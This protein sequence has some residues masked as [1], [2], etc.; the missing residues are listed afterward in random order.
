MPNDRILEQAL[1]YQNK[2][3]VS[4]DVNGEGSLSLSNTQSWCQVTAGRNTA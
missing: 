3:V 2:A 1:T 4:D